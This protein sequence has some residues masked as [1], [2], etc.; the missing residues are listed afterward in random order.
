LPAIAY[1]YRRLGQRV[2]PA[3]ATVVA[4]ALSRRIPCDPQTVLVVTGGNLDEALLD[5]ALA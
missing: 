3:S 4:A 2:E 5:R 1:A